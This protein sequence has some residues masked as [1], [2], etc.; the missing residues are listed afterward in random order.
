MFRRSAAVV[1]LVGAVAFIYGEAVT[2]YFFEDDFQWLVTRWAFHPSHL[3]AFGALSHFYRPVIDLYFWIASPL[4]DGSPVAFHVASIALHAVNG[5]LVYLVASAVGLRPAFAWLAALLFVVQPAYV[6]A[7]AWVGAIAEAIGACFGS[8]AILGLLRFRATGRRAW[9]A[10]G[11]VSFALAL[12]TH[13]SSVVFL[14]LLVL[15]DWTAARF[16]WRPRDILSTY[17]PFVLLAAAYLFVDLTINSRHYL[18]AEGQYRVGVHMIRNVFEYTASLYVGERTL[19][20][21]A[22][23][24]AVMTA[25]ALRGSAIARFS[26]AWMIIAMLPFLPFTFANVSRYAYLPAVGLAMLAAEGLAALDR[27]L[28]RRAATW[29]RLI[30]PALAAVVAVRFAIFA[31]KGVED[32]VERAETY[33]TF[34]SEL[35]RARPVI[36][37]GGTVT[38]D[39][40]TERRMAHRYLEAAVQWEYKNPTIRVVVDPEQ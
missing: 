24:A 38:V 4:F 2:A 9:Q 28:G 27:R 5:G 8:I 18:I 11:A 3:L 19:L 21:H 23:V 31:S 20:A 22:V 39:A 7:V 6:D 35:R 12:L 14:P 33:R 25:V 17:A 40:V 13:E 29:W 34:L 15:A 10:L 16:V 36:G 37:D 1:A 26:L 32:F 30:V